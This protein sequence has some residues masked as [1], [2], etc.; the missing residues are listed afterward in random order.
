MLTFRDHLRTHPDDR[1]RY[2][3]TKTDLAA[4][5]WAYMQDYADA[6]TAIVQD[7]LRRASSADA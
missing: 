1:D 4:Q 2:A 6:K 5:T 7:I 3:Q